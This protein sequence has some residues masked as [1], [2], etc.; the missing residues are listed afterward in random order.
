MIVHGGG[1]GRDFYDEKRYDKCWETRKFTD[2]MKTR[3]QEAM[4]PGGRLCIDESMFSWLGR[5][6]GMPGWKVIKRKSHPFGLEAKVMACAV[7]GM[8]INYEFQEGKDP[9]GYYE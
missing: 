4:K 7:T 1:E 6:L 3:F 2:L 9:M 5:V 8:I